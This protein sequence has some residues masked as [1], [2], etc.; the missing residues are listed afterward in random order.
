MTYATALAQIPIPE[1]TVSV[2][3]G[4]RKS[5]A[6]ASAWLERLCLRTRI[7]EIVAPI[8]ALRDLP[9][10]SHHG[11]CEQQEKGDR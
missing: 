11:Y 10:E 9:K 2:H 7:D 6:E 4:D 5:I 3:V 1:Q 8:H